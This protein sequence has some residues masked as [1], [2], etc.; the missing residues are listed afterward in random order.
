MWWCCDENFVVG[1]LFEKIIIIVLRVSFFLS[2]F[3]S[4][5]LLS[6]SFLVSLFMVVMRLCLLYTNNDNDALIVS[7][8]R[9]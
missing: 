7:G 1:C 2:F 3:L 5:S 8:G 9:R 4:F 6:V